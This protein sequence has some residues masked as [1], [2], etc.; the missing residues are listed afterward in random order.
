MTFSLAMGDPEEELFQAMTRAGIN[1]N[2]FALKRY[3]SDM[4]LIAAP[5]EA[6]TCYTDLRDALTWARM[7]LNE[8]RCTAWA[9]DGYPP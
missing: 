7:K 1:T 9:T 2:N 4:T 5:R 8:D 3:M 6:E